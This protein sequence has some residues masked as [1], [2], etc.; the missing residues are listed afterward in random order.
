MLFEDFYSQGPL[1]YDVHSISFLWLDN[2]TFQYKR[3]LEPVIPV[4]KSWPLKD[5]KG[6]YILP[7]Y[8]KKDAKIFSSLHIKI[9]HSEGVLCCDGLNFMVRLW[10]SVGRQ[11]SLFNQL[12]R[13]SEKSTNEQGGKCVGCKHVT[14][15]SV[16][17]TVRCSKSLIKPFTNDHKSVTALTWV[18]LKTALK[19]ISTCHSQPPYSGDS[20]PAAKALELVDKRTRR[21]FRATDEAAKVVLPRKWL[22]G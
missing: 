9:E 3:T 4:R 18:L 17:Q 21:Y 15:F 12:A 10:L 8:R 16:T 6:S 22:I 1:Y 13:F 20:H 5:S 14:I 7:E 11:G 2:L 19:L